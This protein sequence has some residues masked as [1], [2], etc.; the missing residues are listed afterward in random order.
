MDFLT[1]LI[2]DNFPFCCSCICSQNHSILQLIRVQ[3]VIGKLSL[4]LQQLLVAKENILSHCCDLLPPS[5]SKKSKKKKIR[6]RVQIELRFLQFLFHLFSHRLSKSISKYKKALPS[7]REELYRN[8]TTIRETEKEMSIFTIYLEDETDD[9][10]ACFAELG[11]LSP[12]ALE[13]CISATKVKGE[14]SLGWQIDCRLRHLFGTL[15]NN[16]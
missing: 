6:Y 15:F 14:A 1:I 8:T 5:F 3:D 13:E 10:G 11:H 2:T 16:R 7:S 12:L 9:G 4:S